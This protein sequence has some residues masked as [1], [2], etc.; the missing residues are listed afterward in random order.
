MASIL[1]VS[2]SRNYNEILKICQIGELVLLTKSPQ[3]EFAGFHWVLP[4]IN[5][6]SFQISVCL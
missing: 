6:K 4:Q 2:D 1:P 3:W 5:P